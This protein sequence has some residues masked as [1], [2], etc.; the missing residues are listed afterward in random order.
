MSAESGDQNTLKHKVYNDLRQAIIMGYRQPGDKIDI[1]H[2]ARH[3]GTSVTPVRE[4]MQ[5][6]NQEGLVAIKPHSGFRVT[7]LTLKQLKDL[8]DLREI[9]EVAAVERAVSRITEEQLAQLEACYTGYTGDDDESYTRYTAENRC[10][11]TLIARATG[12]QELTEMVGHL[13]DRLARFMVLR[14]A[15]ETMQVSHARI[16]KALRSRDVSSA[17][18]AMH[19]ELTETREI[20]LERVI[21]DQGDT[22]HLRQ[23]R[24]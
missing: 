6:L 1:R 15:G 7:Q 3:Y 12:N 24:A 23:Q 19:D 21:Q 5:M 2:L 22:W 17:R 8:L 16:I 4:A 11:H 20:L 9:L 10:F 18:Q 14:H 13:H